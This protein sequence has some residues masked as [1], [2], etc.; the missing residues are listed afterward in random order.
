MA[1]SGP[2]G[3]DVGPRVQHG[4]QFARPHLGVRE[5]LTVTGRRVQFEEEQDDTRRAMVE[6]E[7]PPLVLTRHSRPG[8][9]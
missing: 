2:T 7:V 9:S 6:R 3:F 1:V 5:R 4:E 8:E